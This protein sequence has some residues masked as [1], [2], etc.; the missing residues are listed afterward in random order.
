MKINSSFKTK[1][2]SSKFD[3]D[4]FISPAPSESPI[5]SWI[6]NGECS[7]EETERQI[8]EM[9][10]SGIRAFYII[11]E[12]KEFR[13]ETMPTYLEPD[14]LSDGYM[15]QYFYAM[16]YAKKKNMKCWLYDEGG[17]PSGGACGRV[18]ENHPELRKGGLQRTSSFCKKGSKYKKSDSKIIAA[19]ENDTILIDEGYVFSDDAVVFEYFYA[20]V[21]MQDKNTGIDFPDLSYA[22]STDRFIEI[23]HEKYKKHINDYFGDTVT[24]VFT[25]EPKCMSGL[26]PF[27]IELK[28]EFEE[29]YSISLDNYLPALFSKKANTHEETEIIIKWAD[30]ISEKFCENYLLKE[31]HWSNGNNM[32]FTGHMDRDHDPLGCIIGG[33]NFNIMRALRCLDIPG[34]DVIWRQIFPS[35]CSEDEEI[36][37]NGYFPRYAKSAANQINADYCMTES[38]GVYGFGLTFDQMRYV[39]NHQAIR[40]INIF[41]FM[42]VSY[43]KNR[44]CILDDTPSFGKENTLYKHLKDFNKYVERISY[45]V[46]IG[47][48]IKDIALYYPINDILSFSNA[49]K[50][51]ESFDNLGKEAEAKMLDFDIFDD[52]VIE[53]ADDDEILNGVISLGKAKYRTLLIGVSKYIKKSTIQKI[54]SFIKN[55]GVVYQVKDSESVDIDG[56]IIIDSENDLPEMNKEVFSDSDMIRVARRKVDNGEFLLVY[57]ESEKAENVEIL[58]KCQN[59]Y[60]LNLVDGTIRKVNKLE[61]N[62]F[63][64][65]SGDMLVLFFT[66][67]K[68]NCVEEK[69][70]SSSIVLDEFYISKVSQL[71]YSVENGTMINDECEENFAKAELGCWDKAVGIGF[72]GSCKYKTNFTLENTD[73]DIKISLGKVNYSAQ[74]LLNGVDV[75]SCIMEPNEILVS[76]EL[77]KNDNLLEIIVTNT[78]ANELTDKLS[79]TVHE[80][81]Y[82]NKTV[83]FDKEMLDSGLYGPVKIYY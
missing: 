81:G 47:N 23:T 19:F 80:T 42:L 25:D 21:P 32:L 30:F 78:P 26:L 76:K 17:W 61:K 56:A 79:D 40:G 28:K 38:L 65:L 15:E 2:I 54:E 34:I 51:A 9:Y 60:N 63:D 33:A 59:C 20:F 53:N 55:G 66:E 62:S 1:E 49:D 57:N 37:S 83:D 48:D 3:V 73:N 67:D 18:L 12:P 74:I 7:K 10:E 31:K 72:S 45:L 46:S 24:A 8:E 29:K 69:T 35:K 6:W 5:Y 41:N 22:P 52:D 50:S 27:R 68:L 70:Y 13:P 4:N 44:N 36:G 82:Y 16:D 75:G 14:Y 11:P 71:T 39:V 77:L 64:I 43:C 58:T